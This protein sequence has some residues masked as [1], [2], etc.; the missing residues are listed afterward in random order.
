MG[1]FSA[2]TGS[3]RTGFVEGM[4]HHGEGRRNW[5]GEELSGFLYKE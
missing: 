3:N 5:E 1:D 2:Q 4:G